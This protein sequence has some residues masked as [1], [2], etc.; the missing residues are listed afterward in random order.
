QAACGED[1]RHLFRNQL[2]RQRRQ[3]GVDAFGKTV[4]HGNIATFHVAAVLE[5]LAKA[6]DQIAPLGS[7]AVAQKSDHR[8]ALLRAWRAR[9]RSRATKTGDKIAASHGA[10]EASA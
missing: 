8:R 2:R 10:S 4:F 1:H 3:P 5:A 7:K 9:P 6:F